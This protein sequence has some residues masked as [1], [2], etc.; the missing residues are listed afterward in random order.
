V[1]LHKEAEQYLGT[2]YKPAGK[3]N[4]EIRLDVIKTCDS[5]FSFDDKTPDASITAAY[6]MSKNVFTERAATK[7]K[8]EDS[9]AALMRGTRGAVTTDGTDAPQ[10]AENKS[11]NAWK[12]K[13][14]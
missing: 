10:T 1:Q 13:A 2:E 7:A 14:S 4:R 12:T 9:L 3:S 11:Q 8:N 5:K 6:E